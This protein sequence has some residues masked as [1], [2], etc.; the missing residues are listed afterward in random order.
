MVMYSSVM[1]SVED[2]FIDLIGLL[3]GKS[4][5]TG[6]FL[7]IILLMFILN[8]R[9]CSLLCKCFFFNERLENCTVL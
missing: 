4:R 2:I 5:C 1:W 8:P 7:F 9:T 6:F 3:Y